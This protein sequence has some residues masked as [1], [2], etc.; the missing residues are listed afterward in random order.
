MLADTL[1]LSAIYESNGTAIAVPDETMREMQR[2]VGAAKGSS[3]CPE[4]GACV[5]AMEALL[6][7]GDID[8]DEEVVV[9][10]TAT[11]LKYA[12]SRAG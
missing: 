10:N 11:A 2:V 8:H 9:F 6:D 12:R 3:M 5:A 1:C 4:G 7:R